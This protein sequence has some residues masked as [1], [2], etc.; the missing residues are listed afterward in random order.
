MN[1][2]IRQKYCTECDYTT[3]DIKQNCCPYCCVGLR[4]RTLKHVKGVWK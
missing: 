1:E 4:L 2:P 3:D